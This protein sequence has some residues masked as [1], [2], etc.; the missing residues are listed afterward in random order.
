MQEGIELDPLKAYHYSQLGITYL[1]AG[2][3]TEAILTMRKGLSLSPDLVH[4]HGVAAVAL[5]LS[6]KIDEAQA[7]NALEKGEE[8]HDQIETAILHAQGKT[9]EALAKY[10]I[11]A[12][13]Y[14]SQVPNMVAG[15][16]SQ[17]QL[18]DESIYWLT[19]ALETKT[20]GME[21]ILVDPFMNNMRGNPRFIEIIERL[22]FPTKQTESKE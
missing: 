4:G 14:G 19:K 2:K 12:G 6:S 18:P 10:T 3:Y 8:F 7:E 21:Y 1:F 17:I 5:L 13:K 15:L 22:N 20:G 11:F 16:A 9:T